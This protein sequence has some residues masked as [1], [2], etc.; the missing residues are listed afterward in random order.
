LTSDSPES[1]TAYREQDKP[2]P[3]H[4][5]F[6]E[7]WRV[8]WYSRQRFDHYRQVG[9]LNTQAACADHASVAV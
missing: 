3:Y 6:W 8:M 5:T 7:P 4:S 1:M 2:F 9:Y